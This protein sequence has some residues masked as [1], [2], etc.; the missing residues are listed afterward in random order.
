MAAPSLTEEQVRQ[1]VRDEVA[2]SMPT[3]DGAEVHR[4]SEALRRA[5][6]RQWAI[7]VIAFVLG[8]DL[9][10]DEGSAPK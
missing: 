7:G 1:I 5:P 2:V 10:G 8:Y 9:R 3:T 4:V 6:Q